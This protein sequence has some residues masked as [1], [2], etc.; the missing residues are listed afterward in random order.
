LRIGVVL[1]HG[2]GRQIQRLASQSGQTPSN[3]DG[4]G[5]TDAATL[6]L[7]LTASTRVTHEILEGLA[8]ND[9]RG[10]SGNAVVAHPA[11]ILQGVD[12]QFT[13]R[14]DR[15]DTVL[16]HALLERDIVPVVPPLGIDGEGHS[17]RLNSDVVAVE[18]A[19]SLHAIKLIF[20]TPRDGVHKGEELLRHLMVDDAEAI[21]KKPQSDVPAEEVS[22]LAQA[23]RAVR[24][25]VERV[26]IIDGRVEMGLLAEV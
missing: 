9:L 19:Q 26:H 14:I 18:V 24:G 1:V 23:V 20:L 17:F 5:L 3:I 11:G 13:G 2:A 7:A 21:L 8:A 6:Q 25:G 4:T 22:K 15:V 12:H 16:L 10:A